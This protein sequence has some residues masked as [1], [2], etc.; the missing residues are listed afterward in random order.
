MYRATKR[1]SNRTSLVVNKEMIECAAEK[2]ILKWPGHSIFK[3]TIEP[4]DEKAILGLVEKMLDAAQQGFSS[5]RESAKYDACASFGRKLPL[6]RKRV[7]EDIASGVTREAAL[8]AVRQARR[9]F[10]GELVEVDATSKI[11][12]NPSKKATE[13][14]ITGRYG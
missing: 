3:V 9:R 6:V 11:F 1:G 5:Q 7:E 12:T 14:Y 13:D 2:A 8:A 10:L 4:F